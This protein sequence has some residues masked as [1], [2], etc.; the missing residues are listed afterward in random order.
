[1]QVVKERQIRS[2]TIELIVIIFINGGATAELV[3]F[4]VLYVIKVQQRQRSAVGHKRNGLCA[5]DW[6]M[7][8]NSIC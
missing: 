2:T 4:T 6:V 5:V 3:P 1:M 7:I 8:I